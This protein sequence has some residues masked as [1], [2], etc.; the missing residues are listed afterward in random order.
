MEKQ[1]RQ[2]VIFKIWSEY[3]PPGKVD[4]V[5][6]IDQ[7]EFFP[8]YVTEMILFVLLEENGSTDVTVKCRA[9]SLARMFENIKCQ[10][11]VEITS[12][13]HLMVIF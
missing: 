2:V 3:E 8:V 11:V 9:I 12:T 4:S 10:T 5:G 6:K 1:K 13:K 7:N